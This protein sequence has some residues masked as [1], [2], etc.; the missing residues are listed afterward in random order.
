MGDP[1]IIEAAASVKSKELKI[2]AITV[3]T[4]LDRNDLNKNLIKDGSLDE[5][6][7][8]RARL[9]Y[10]AGADGVV[11]SPLEIRLIRSLDKSFRESS[12]RCIV[13]PGIRPFHGNRHDQKR[14]MTRAD[15][16]GNGASY[17]VIGRPIYEA[18]NPY[19]MLTEG[20]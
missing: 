4:N 6:V 9:A 2:L 1:H 5:I 20:L 18:T 14:V 16:L 19:R 12:D 15:A 7:K 13:T 3:L 10:E 17:V 8:E 11:C